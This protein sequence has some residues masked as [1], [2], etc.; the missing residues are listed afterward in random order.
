M[1]LGA[2][3]LGAGALGAGASIFGS[4]TQSRSASQARQAMLDMFNMAKGEL[5]PFIS[6]GQTGVKTLTDLLT[7]GP[8]MTATL[9]NIPGFQFLQDWG[10]RAVKNMGSTRGLGGN[11]GT[12][13]AQF[14]TGTAES[15]GFFPLVQ[16]LLGLS[17]QGQAAASS[18]L[19]GATGVGSN[20]GSTLM[21][22]GQALAGGATGVAN[23][24]SGALGNYF[25]YSLLSRLLGNAGG[26]GA[27]SATTDP[28]LT[29][30]SA[31]G[32]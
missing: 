23:A 20:V 13:L 29:T 7:P 14:A 3:I 21:A 6:A 16:S 22:G 8:N 2:A 15:Q 9:N 11:V 12:A 25:N 28:L 18:L 32:Q 1:P 10:Q 17:G 27:W 24:A 31:G 30:L 19:G 5:Q 4:L 26:G